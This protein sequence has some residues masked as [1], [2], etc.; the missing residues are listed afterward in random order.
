VL[1]LNKVWSAGLGV[2]D[3]GVWATLFL[4]LAAQPYEFT[5]PRPRHKNDAAWQ[6]IHFHSRS[7]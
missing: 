7:Q 4:K 6:N 2:P 3:Q 5:M 1:I